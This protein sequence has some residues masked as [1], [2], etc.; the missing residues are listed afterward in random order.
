MEP[1]PLDAGAFTLDQLTVAD[2]PAL[3]AAL[4]DGEIRR[5]LPGYALADADAARAFIGFRAWQWATG[6]RFSWAVRD[7]GGALAGEVG[8][9]DVNPRDRAVS[10][11]CWTAAAHRGRGVAAT[12][13]TA[14]LRYA[15]DVA[16]AHRVGYRHAAGNHGSRRVAEKCGFTLEGTS[17][18]AELVDG[19]HHDLLQWYRLATD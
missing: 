10:V 12:A 13:L 5:R 14:A 8:L 3:L 4:A 15:F 7:A 16:G 9:R 6:E 17:R 11:F 19:R 18:G 1:V 2:G